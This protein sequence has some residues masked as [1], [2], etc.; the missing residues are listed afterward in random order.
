MWPALHGLAA[1]QTLGG[2][3]LADAYA[4]VIVYSAS[5][6]ACAAAIE[7]AR[8]GRSVIIVGGWREDRVGGMMS[9]GL[10]ATDLRNEAAIGG[11]GRE[12]F[13]AINAHYFPGGGPYTYR[14]EPSV[15]QAA[16]E[17]KLAEHDIPVVWTRGIV[18]CVREGTAIRR[19]KTREGRTFACR[20]LLASGYEGDEVA[21]AGIPYRIGREGV[22]EYGE[23][24][25]GVR[26]NFNGRHQFW[27]PE[28]VM[29]LSPFR[30]A[31]NA[32]SGLL[33]GMSPAP[34]PI[35]SA[36]EAVQ[37]Y[38]F[39]L[40]L[41]T[42]PDRRR[43]LMTSP[44][45]GYDPARYELLGRYLAEMA[46]LG[47]AYYPRVSV[48][49]HF[50]L[51]ESL[52]GGKLDG[53]ARGPFSTDPFGLSWAY[54]DAGFRATGA[55]DF[56]LRE[57]IWQQ[58]RQHVEGLFWFAQSSGDSRVWPDLR[59]EWRT[60]WL[61]NDQFLQPGF[62]DPVGWP[63]QLYVREA[64]RMVGDFVLTEQDITRPEW[65]ETTYAD[66]VI[67]LASYE[68][69]SHHVRRYAMPAPGTPSGHRAMNE[70]DFF[71]AVGGENRMV[72][73]P[74]DV[75]LPPRRACTNMLATWA[76]SAT[77]VATG[78]T[79]MEPTH[80][81]LGHAAGLAAVLAL[82]GIRQHAVHDI[83]VAE[84]RAQLRAEGAALDDI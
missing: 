15:A 18:S 41:S 20:I 62:G 40:C 25:A 8:H 34:G 3:Q 61:A 76:V 12:I 36:D 30:V 84:L 31:G 19:I 37:A 14:F 80:M 77:H 10:G 7:V 50:L 39:R 55:I 64:R 72:P 35:G 51:L 56:D 46:R 13:D 42:N 65:Q 45:E 60:Y 1:S 79:R 82:D 54:P 43:P 68:A 70:G 81:A 23:P 38:N 16:F 58:H 69:D 9:G 57:S 67:G 28:G 26:R 29:N 52:P 5:P 2:G 83:N 27:G 21:V 44:P 73:I 48:P 78:L 74:Y 22:G 53:N 71:F 24:T 66:R 75:M 59:E 17:A 32:A 49:T 47:I 33:P 6:G 11:I 63:S 4:D